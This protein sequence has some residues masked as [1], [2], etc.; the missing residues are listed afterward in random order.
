MAITRHGISADSGGALMRCSLVEM[1][2]I[3][4]EAAAA[5]RRMTVAE[6]VIFGQ[7]APIGTGSFDVALD[8]EMLKDVIVDHCLPVQNM[9]VAPADGDMTPGQVAMTPYDNVSPGW[10]EHSFKA[11]AAAFDDDG[12]MAFITQTIAERK[13]N[14]MQII[15]DASH[16]K[17]K[18]I[19]V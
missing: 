11:G 2:E 19:L 16:D 10:S 6:N 1:V 12:M 7:I 8:M 13:A 5:G 18:R 3:L 15:E 17:L 14:A 9:L 4:M